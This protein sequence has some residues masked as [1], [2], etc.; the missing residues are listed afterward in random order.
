MIDSYGV[1]QLVE[2]IQEIKKIVSDIRNKLIFLSSHH[3]MRATHGPLRP[4]LF[5]ISMKRSVFK[6]SI[7]YSLG[8]A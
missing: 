3:L 7:C 5:L 2:Y 6:A 8:P 1:L 4:Y